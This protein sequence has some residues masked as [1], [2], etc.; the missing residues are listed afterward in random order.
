MGLR[1]RSRCSIGLHYHAIVAIGQVQKHCL[2]HTAESTARRINKSKK[3]AMA[4][5][6]HRIIGNYSS[7]NWT[8]R[9]DTREVTAFCSSG[10]IDGRTGL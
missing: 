3:K 10:L 8:W 2:E 4:E 7:P 9:A 1:R 5:D 6:R